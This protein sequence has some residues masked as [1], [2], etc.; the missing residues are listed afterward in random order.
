MIHDTVV[1]ACSGEDLADRRYDLHYET[2]PG[3]RG[4]FGCKLPI[5]LRPP[6]PVTGSQVLAPA[7]LAPAEHVTLYWARRSNPCFRALFA[8]RFK[9][10]QLGHGTRRDTARH[11]NSGRV[12]RLLPECRRKPSTPETR[13][14]EPGSG[15]PES[16]WR[17]P[18]WEFPSSGL[19][20]CHLL[21]EF[22][23]TCGNNPAPSLSRSVTPSDAIWAASWAAPTGFASQG[24]G[25]PTRFASAWPRLPPGAGRPLRPRGHSCPTDASD[26]R[27]PLD[28]GGRS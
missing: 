10:S 16:N 11:G 8:A 28:T 20:E 15:R 27:R 5:E 13:A 3:E 18:A 26:L 12:S 21:S 19:T 9:I 14:A 25:R 4:F 22:K 7:G 2:A 17:R 23:F 6:I 24:H 1:L